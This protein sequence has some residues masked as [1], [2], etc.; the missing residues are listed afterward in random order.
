MVQERGCH[1]Q[2]A[3]SLGLVRMPGVWGKRGPFR[4]KRQQ[5]S[6]A[7]GWGTGQRAF[8]PALWLQAWGGAASPQMR[9]DHHPVFPKG[10]GCRAQRAHFPEQVR[11]ARVCRTAV[12]LAGGGGYDQSPTLGLQLRGLPRTSGLDGLCLLLGLQGTLEREKKRLVRFLFWCHIDIPKIVGSLRQRK[13]PEIRSIWRRDGTLRQALGPLPE[14]GHRRAGS[15]ACPPG[16]LREGWRG[17]LGCGWAAPH[18]A[19]GQ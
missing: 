1:P 10:S 12:S 3:H 7:G 8:R 13:S 16:R 17:F 11:A 15:G 6:W 18:E 5:R 2:G 19:W 4:R 14:K 9:H